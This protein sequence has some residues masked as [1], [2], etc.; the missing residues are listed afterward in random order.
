MG[1]TASPYE[2]GLSAAEEKYYNATWK[3]SET[4]LVGAGI[5]GGFVDTSE[6]HG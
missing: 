1:A 5:G 3:I 2:I 6:L 4:A